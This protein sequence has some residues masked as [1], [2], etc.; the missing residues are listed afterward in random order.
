MP[1]HQTNQKKFQQFLR[2]LEQQGNFSVRQIRE[3]LE[4]SDLLDS[5][6][7]TYFQTQ[8][9]QRKH[10]QRLSFFLGLLAIASIA[11]IGGFAG[12]GILVKPEIEQLRSTITE[13]ETT[14]VASEEQATESKEYLNELRDRI[15]ARDEQLQNAESD[16]QDKN[17]TIDR[18]KTQLSAEEAEN[19]TKI[20]QLQADL[21]EAKS[22]NSESAANPNFSGNTDRNSGS[23]PRANLQIEKKTYTRL[24]PIVVNFSF[25]NIPYSERRQIT[26]GLASNSQRS[27]RNNYF[28]VGEDGTVTFKP[29]KP[30]NYEI[31]A[32]VYPGNEWVQIEK[33]NI[34]IT[35]DF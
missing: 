10:R 29:Q 24:E 7:E 6:I 33:R 22:T 21:T 35:A 28:N 17:E 14:I 26:L 25:E 1:E 8:E 19:E 20:A 9:R 18:L 30:G 13:L 32:Y 5:L 27:Y 11:G 31:R 16:L 4:E 15:S 12:R 2:E 34:E 3:T 23:K